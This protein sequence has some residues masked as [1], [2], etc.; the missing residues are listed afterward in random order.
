VRPEKLVEACT[1]QQEVNALVYA[2][3]P[4]HAVLLV[5]AAVSARIESLLAGDYAAPGG[6]V[7]LKVALGEGLR[8]LL[9]AQADYRVRQNAT[10]VAPEPKSA[11]LV[12]ALR[13]LLEG[14]PGGYDD[15][16]CHKGICPREECRQCQRVD[17]ARAAI[18]KAED[19]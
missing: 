5:E 1:T 6:V 4:D 10:V 14:V 13:Q 11:D 17:R 8:R 3:A 7:T 15:A 2:L 9:G 12:A 16:I 18:A 19:R